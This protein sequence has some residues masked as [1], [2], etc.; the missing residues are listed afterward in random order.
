MIFRLIL[1][2]RHKLPHSYFILYAVRLNLITLSVY[3]FFY[4]K[5]FSRL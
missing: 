4:N 2:E 5:L 1:I 3:I